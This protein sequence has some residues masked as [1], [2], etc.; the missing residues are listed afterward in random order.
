MG[1]VIHFQ[2]PFVFAERESSLPPSSASIYCSLVSL[3]VSECRRH[4]YSVYQEFDPG[5]HFRRLPPDESI[6]GVFVRLFANL[7]SVSN[8]SIP[9][10]LIERDVD[11]TTK[12]QMLV[13]KFQACFGYYD[14]S[15]C[16]IIITIDAT[17]SKTFFFSCD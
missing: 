10:D 11:V 17:V 8:T 5:R 6:R 13:A 16:N 1:I 12:H 4:L 15:S 7:I 9:N 2:E 14:R 3:P